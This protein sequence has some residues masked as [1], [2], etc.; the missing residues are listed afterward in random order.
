MKDPLLHKY[1]VV[2]KE[3]LAF[4]TRMKPSMYLWN[5]TQAGVL[6]NPTSTRSTRINHSF[7]QETPEKHDYNLQPVEAGCFCHGRSLS[8]IMY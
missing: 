4:L 2:V 8:K 5:I 1:L 3:K 6:S 7:I